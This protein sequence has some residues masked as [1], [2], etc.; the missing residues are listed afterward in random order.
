M[1][2]RDIV[3]DPLKANSFRFCVLDVRTMA[4]TNE[5]RSW[6]KHNGR[7]RTSVGRTVLGIEYWCQEATTEQ[8]CLRDTG[9]TQNVL[10]GPERSRSDLRGKSTRVTREMRG[11][12]AAGNRATGKTNGG[13]ARVRW[14]WWR[15]SAIRIFV[16]APAIGPYTIVIFNR[17]T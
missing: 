11:T 6:S 7:R 4:V 8:Y 1:Y 12:A 5:L 16:Y 3:V 2:A 9:R 14:H 15:P 17:G 10:A 13:A